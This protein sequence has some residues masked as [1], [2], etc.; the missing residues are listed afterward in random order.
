MLTHSDQSVTDEEHYASPALLDI[1]YCPGADKLA[2]EAFGDD[3]NPHRVQLTQE[4]AKGVGGSELGSYF[5][6]ELSYLKPD[7]KLARHI[8]N[9]ALNFAN[10]NEEH[11]NFFGSN[12][13]GVY[14]IVFTD[15]MRFDFFG[16]YILNA[17]EHDL[18]YGL[19]HLSCIEPSRKVTS[20]V[21]SHTII[22]LIHLFWNSTLI[23]DK[24]R[25]QTC[26]DLIRIMHY[27]FLSSLLNYRFR[28][29]VDINLA[30]AVYAAFSKKFD[31]RRYGS[32]Q[33]LIDARA[34]AIIS[35]ES[36]HW[37][38]IT[39][40]DN[41][42]RI[43]YMISDIQT[44]IR[45]VVNNM[46]TVFYEVKTRTDKILIENLTSDATGEKVVKDVASSFVFFKRRIEG[47]MLDKE[48][49][50]RQ[51]VLEL[52]MEATNATDMKSLTEF[53]TYMVLNKHKDK[54]VYELVDNILIHLFEFLRK[55]RLKS[56][57]LL[58]IIEKI[59]VLYTASK[60]TNENVMEMRRLGTNITER[61]VS[62]KSSSIRSSV[63]TTV[64]V[65]IVLMTLAN[66]K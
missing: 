41:D 45:D 63:R 52:A 37:N 50:I 19:H 2:L 40:Y 42:Q 38:T 61:A 57:E 60:S 31:I 36:I 14:K 59:K 22:Y 5:S 44:R 51:D 6:G 62:Q 20:D 18:T 39:R 10:L 47:Y 48:S 32:W 28:Y 13:L 9:F 55:N 4:A 8:T 7:L 12:L 24:V 53:L 56:N 3:D 26:K 34:D 49:F 54:E 66:L 1:F 16:D 11:I 30:K 58:T 65:Y 35:K 33:G 43:L 23:N 25:E 15:D 29:R 21:V 27:R 64:C 46:T 17:D